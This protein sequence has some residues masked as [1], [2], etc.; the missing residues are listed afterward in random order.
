MANINNYKDSIDDVA[1]DNVESSEGESDSEESSRDT[2]RDEDD[3]LS[4]PIYARDISD[5]LY[6][7]GIWLDELKTFPAKI[8]VW[9]YE[10]FPYLEKYV[11]KSLGTPLPISRILKWHTSKSEDVVVGDPFKYKGRSTKAQ[12]KSE[13][14]LIE[15]DEHLGDHNVHCVN[16]LS[17][18]QNNVQSTSNDGNL[19]YLSDLVLYL[20]QSMVEV[21]AYVRAE[22]LRRI[23]KNKQKKQEKSKILYVNITTNNKDLAVVDEDFAAIDEYFTNGVDEVTVDGVAIDKVTSDGVIVDDVI[24]EVVCEVDEVA[25]IDEVAGADVVDEVKSDEVAGVVYPMT[26]IDVVDEVEGEVDLL[27][28]LMKWQVKL[29]K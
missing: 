5:E 17:N 18:R 9:I 20:E 8:T 14:I 23:E 29:I 28:F 1:N 7:L 2:S 25:I 13:T 4:L 11:G 10:A 26:V 6:D 16:S 15:G 21:V 12:L 19:E 24:D 3:P 27:T 22:K